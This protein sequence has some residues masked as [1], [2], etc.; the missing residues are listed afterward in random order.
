MGWI[1][2][3]TFINIC[4]SMSSEMLRIV[5]LFWKLQQFVQAK[6]PKT[7]SIPSALL[8]HFDA[9]KILSYITVMIICPAPTKMSHDIV[10]RHAR[11]VTVQHGNHT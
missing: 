3:L 9:E 5:D 2:P 4:H 1:V 7:N 8:Y 11:K 10:I 6:H